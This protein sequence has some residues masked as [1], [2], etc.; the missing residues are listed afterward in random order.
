MDRNSL[1][2]NAQKYIQRGQLDRAIE[3]YRKLLQQDPSDVRLLLKIADLEARAGQQADA[4]S[5]YR[6]AAEHFIARKFLFKAL[7][8][9]KQLEKLAPEDIDVRL[10]LADLHVEVSLAQDAAKIYHAVIRELERDGKLI[11]A[12]DVMTRLVRIEPDDIGLQIRLAELHARVQD[13]AAAS[14]I[15]IEAAGRL[16]QEG[17]H[18][19]YVRLGE[20]ILAWKPGHVETLK[21]LAVAQLAL[22]E[23][24]KAVARAQEAL[25]G[26]PRDLDTL[27]VL[28]DALQALGEAERAVALLDGLEKRFRQDGH[29]DLVAGL[30]T[31]RARLEQGA[32]EP[33]S[34]AEAAGEDTAGAE[35][36]LEEVGVYRK[37]GLA[38]KALA[39]IDRA[40]TLAPNHAPAWLLRAE[41]LEEQGDRE[42]AAE[43]R[44]R[45]EGQSEPLAP[46]RAQ[47]PVEVP[48]AKND[49]AI[50]PPVADAP[51]S[52]TLADRDPGTLPDALRTALDGVASQLSDDPDGAR[53]SLLQMLG[54]WPSEAELLLGIM[55]SLAEL[56]DWLARAPGA[57]EAGLIELDAV[58][59]EPLD[60][61]GA[62]PEP[63]DE[64]DPFAFLDPE[65]SLEESSD[66]ADPDDDPGEPG[67]EAVLAA[68]VETALEEEAL[69]LIPVEALE[70]DASAGEAEVDAPPGR[71]SSAVTRVFALSQAVLEHDPDSP[72]AEAIRQRYAGSGLAAM[73]TLEEEVF[74]VHT[75]AAS[76]E[77]AAVQLE[78][79]LYIEAAMALDG[80]ARVPELEPEDQALILYLR[81]VCME[82]LDDL[83]GMQ[84]AFEGVDAT[85]RVHF[86]DI[87]VRLARAGI[88]A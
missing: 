36:L 67:R 17:R 55:G 33:A 47:D 30:G 48:A 14:D 85:A 79:G 81:G 66:L 61:P 19:E 13:T 2:A 31:I 57:E 23:P 16:S 86:P 1:V 45:A 7:A 24:R 74:G 72:L 11:R 6:Q 10:R 28:V 87:A 68:D 80:I 34:D 5:S 4:I 58:E 82:G 25:R 78:M 44:R 73:A 59:F 26:A 27:R 51:A 29:E 63:D 50:A 20:R 54:D 42:G 22:G 39:H 49:E 41:I 70:S 60:E 77:L 83:D 9:Y 3:A 52:A 18:D 21:G 38:D 43:A 65:D 56:P 76:F 15:M 35:H 88:T 75:V 32:A 8:V 64:D 46:L 84:Q 37:Y 62:P 71:P 40:L 53:S 69:P 12:I